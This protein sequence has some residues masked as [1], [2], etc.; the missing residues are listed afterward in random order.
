[1]LAQAEARRQKRNYVGNEHVLLGLI[2]IDST[3]FKNR[4]YDGVPFGIASEAL[5]NTRVSLNAVRA[6][7]DKID[8]VR[9][10]VAVEIPFT[11]RCKKLLERSWEVADELGD[12]LV[13]T[14]HLLIAFLDDQ[15]SAGYNI[16]RWLN[17][18]ID[19]LRAEIF[20]LKGETQNHNAT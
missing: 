9:T 11:P 8:P 5:A 1:M 15:E 18:D 7:V 6:E 4:H 12:K 10:S 16:L 19:A 3:D 13:D 20:R 17:L 14:E 2:A